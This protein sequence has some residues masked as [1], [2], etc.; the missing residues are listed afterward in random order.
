MLLLQ[1]RQADASIVHN[2]YWWIARA[3]LEEEV[4]NSSEVIQLFEQALKE[5]HTSSYAMVR[6]RK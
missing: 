3:R 2:P 6:A 4:H 1:L 5:C